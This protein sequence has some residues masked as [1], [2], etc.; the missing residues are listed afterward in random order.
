MM[1]RCKP[2]QTMSDKQVAPSAERNGGS[3]LEVLRTEF[4]KCH[5]V[6]EIGSGTGQ[7]AVRFAS[8]MEYLQWQTSDL[9]EN[10]E[11]IKAWI[12]DAGLGNIAFPLSLDVRTATLPGN[13]YDGIYSSNTAHIMS[14]AAVK[15]M[16]AIVGGALCD[17]G[18][19]CLYGPLR[20]DGDF[21]TTSNA[22]FHQALCARDPESGIRD[23]EDLDAFGAQH[24]LTRSKLY[25]MP[26]N[27]HIAVWRKR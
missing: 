7:H 20:Q 5:C 26:A 22:A 11:C 25:A 10:H 15:S 27:N 8:A 17:G 2:A 21:N 6:L 24:G 19:F 12:V 4:E 3:I 1:P 14:L 23:L 9:D 13:S 18:A 16:F